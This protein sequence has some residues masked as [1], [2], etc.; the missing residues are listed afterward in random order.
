MLRSWLESFRDFEGKLS[1]L[2]HLAYQQRSSHC[3][4]TLQN[5]IGEGPEALTES[6][7][8]KQAFVL[9]RHYLGRLGSHLRAAKVLVA[10][11]SRMP[12]LLDS[13]AVRPRQSPKPP[14][15]PPPTDHLTTLTGILGR[16]LPKGSRDIAQYQEAL[17][18]MNTKFKLQDRLID[19]YQDKSF[20]PRVH[21]ELNL[22][23]YFYSENL[24]FVDDDKFIGC[25]KPACYCC[26]HYI[27]QHPGG[28]VRPPSHGVRYLNWR[29]PDL[30]DT[31]GEQEQNHQRDVLNKVI[32]QIRQD[33][34]RHIERRGG[35]SQWRPDSTTGIT[36]SK[37]PGSIVNEIISGGLKD[38][39]VTGLPKSNDLKFN[40]SNKYISA[41]SSPN[42]SPLPEV[43]ESLVEEVSFSREGATDSDQD[44]DGGV[45]LA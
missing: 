10:A 16:M 45:L 18:V 7:S 39:S 27:C 4:K 41:G 25:S 30:P 31:A 44:S 21:A 34:L 37:N 1:D 2:C 20:R 32:A 38:A 33:T 42:L 15:L 23:D 8:R 22:L 5:H 11:G 29:P 26:Y 6:E 36:Y 17:A 35:R 19:V 28:F 40:A 3:M 43:R 24:A 14:S 13:C 12:G 9:T